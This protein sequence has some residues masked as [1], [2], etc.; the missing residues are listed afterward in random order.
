ML[1]IVILTKTNLPGALKMYKKIVLDNGE[2]QKVQLVAWEGLAKKLEKI[3]K[4]GMVKFFN[5]I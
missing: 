3:D 1:G 2:G 5:I 4:V